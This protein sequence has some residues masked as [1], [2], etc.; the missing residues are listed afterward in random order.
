MMHTVQTK[1]AC[2]LATESKVDNFVTY[3]LK[4]KL[5]LNIINIVA[6]VVALL[7]V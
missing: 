5:H 2:K 6:C 3:F 1:V 4:S 7:L